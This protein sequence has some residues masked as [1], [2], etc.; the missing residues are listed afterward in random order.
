M[1]ASSVTQLQGLLYSCGFGLLLGAWYSVW[2]WRQMSVMRCAVCDVVFCL[3]GAVLFFLF[4]LTVTGGAFRWYLFCGTATG[5]F[6]WRAT[7]GFLLKKVVYITSGYFRTVK[8]R[9]KRTKEQMFGNIH[10]FLKK[11]CPKTH[12]FFKKHLQRKGQLVY[13]KRGD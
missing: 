1:T 11:T 10:K 8:K 5:F 13:N 4:T 7:F 3:S 6:T 2:H 9:L 12:I